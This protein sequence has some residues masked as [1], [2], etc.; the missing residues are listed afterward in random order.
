M[1]KTGTILELKR[2]RAIIM[3][4]ECRYVYIKRRPKMFVGQQVVFFESDLIKP[5]M[6]V[7]KYVG[8]AA[9]IAVGFLLI[10]VSYFRLIENRNIYA[11]VNVDINPS[12]EIAVDQEKVVLWAKPIN[13]DGKTLLNTL[14]LKGE[15]LED[16]IK[17]IV[18]QSRKNGIIKEETDNYILISV[19]LNPKNIQNKANRVE[20]ETKLDKYLNSF[21]G[22]SGEEDKER[23]ICE[24][25]HTTMEDREQAVKNQ[26]SSGKYY[27]YRKLIE[28][29]QGLSID[30]IRKGNISDLLDKL[31]VDS[32]SSA[33][34]DEIPAANHEAPEEPMKKAVKV[35]GYNG[36]TLSEE[37]E[38]VLISTHETKKDDVSA[39][40]S[41]VDPSSPTHNTAPPVVIKPTPTPPV[42]TP[43]LPAETPAKTSEKPAE[44]N[45]SPGS[46]GSW[47][48][49][50]QYS[51]GDVVE[52]EGKKF[53]CIQ[54]HK[55]QADWLTP[56][57][58]ALWQMQVP[59]DATNTWQ[60]GISYKSGSIVLYQG[61]K[62]KCLQSHTSIAGWEPPSVP[63]LW[64]KQP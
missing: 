13:E 2:N 49:G 9:S 15:S 6:A 16:A 50:V 28:N 62:Y 45:N 63:A 3:T 32:G 38:E 46:N 39:T 7:F 52:Y 33:S 41:K 21:K 10:F 60:T 30:E 55:S 58:P 22:V 40:P 12:V 8:I 54:A 48:A 27:V 11:F 64:E 26:I 59:N 35:D 1:N 20:E 37:Q 56:E 17:D 19:S 14:K 5:R 42:H 34:I 51:I 61:L 4:N 23:I 24:V 29:G 31:K 25:I 44:G 36:N 18:D 47:R 43:V 53:R 57:V